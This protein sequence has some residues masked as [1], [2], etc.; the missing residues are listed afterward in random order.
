MTCFKSKLVLFSLSLSL[1]FSAGLFAQDR[2]GELLLDRIATDSILESTTDTD[3]LTEWVDVL[4]DHPT[5]PSPREVLG[6]TIGTP[7]ELTQVD[8]IYRYFDALAAASDR[9][10]IFQLGQ[11]FE[12]RDMLVIA[13]A[14]PEHLENL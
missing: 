5:V 1:S 10:R 6:Y 7:G 13:I 12:E 14:E 9:V 4:P 3:F 8:D 11:S 2:V